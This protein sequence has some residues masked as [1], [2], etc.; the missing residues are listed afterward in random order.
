MKVFSILLYLVASSL[1]VLGDELT[2]ANQQFQAKDFNGAVA[3]YQKLLAKEGPSSVVYYNLGNTYQQLKQYGPAIHA[4]EQ[5]RLLTPRDPDLLK[6]MALARK[7]AVA[8]EQTGRQPW[9]DAVLTRLSR[10]EWSWLVVGASL[11]TGV[12]VLAYG[13]IT[14]PRRVAWVTA[15]ICA[16]AMAVGSTALYLR[17]GEAAHGI[18]LTADANVR[19]SPFET[20][21]A[22]ATLRPGSVVS[23]G[24]K[25]GSFQYIQIPNN[26]LNGWIASNDVAAITVENLPPQN[27]TK[28]KD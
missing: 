11:L 22:I 5:A 28:I 26:G 19:L 8:R 12:V 24:A 2:R 25:N 27:F 20:A 4:Y 3:S 1:S 7:N 21:E 10:N 15:G 13:L 23:L 16:F 18:V 14:Y 9:L 17:R 6:N